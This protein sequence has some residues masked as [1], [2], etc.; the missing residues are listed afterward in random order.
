MQDEMLYVRRGNTSSNGMTSANRFRSSN[1]KISIN[2]YNENEST[3]TE[4]V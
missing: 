1:R 4:Q 3:I 2:K